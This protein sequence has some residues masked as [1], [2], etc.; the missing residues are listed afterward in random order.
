MMPVK[1]I[2]G[3]YAH[4]LKICTVKYIIH[5]WAN[6]Y[7]VESFGRFYSNIETLPHAFDH[8]EFGPN[9]VGEE[10]PANSFQL[11]MGKIQLLVRLICVDSS[12]NPIILTQVFIL[13]PKLKFNVLAKCPKLSWE[14]PGV[15][16]AQWP[17]CHM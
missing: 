1:P 4:Y 17:K 6:T 9:V 10:E 7:S 11:L 15:S 8:K 12:G 5:S 3:D 2:F 14:S 13:P 16:T